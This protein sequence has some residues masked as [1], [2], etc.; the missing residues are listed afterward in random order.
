MLRLR[1]ERFGG[2]ANINFQMSCFIKKTLGSKRTIFRRTHNYIQESGAGRRLTRPN[3]N[4]LNT[5][6]TFFTFDMPT[7][8]IKLN[9]EMNTIH[10]NSKPKLNN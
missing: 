6:T 9:T 4:K 10:A 2:K 7:F 8:T 1:I 3:S 5:T